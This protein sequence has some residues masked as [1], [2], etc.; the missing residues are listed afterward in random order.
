MLDV[1]LAHEPSQHYFLPLA[2]AFGP[3]AEEPATAYQ[4]QVLAR[5]RKGPRIGLLIDATYDERFAGALVTAMA[6]DARVPTARGGEVRFIGSERLRA[7]HLQTDAPAQR[8]GRE[9]SNSSLTVGDSM[10][11][12]VLRRVQPGIHPELEVSRFL[13]EAGFRNTPSFLGGIELQAQDGASWALAVLQGR[14]QNQGDGWSWTLDHLKRVLDEAQLMAAPQEGSADPHGIYGALITTL[15]VRVA[16]MHRAFATPVDDPAFAPEPVTP[17]DLQR[18]A[19]DARV[20]GRAARAALQ[21]N[22][23]SIAEEHRQ[24]AE[25]LLADWQPVEERIAE[26]APGGAS[27]LK[28]RLHGD[29]HLGQVLLC[30]DDFSII[31]FEGEPARSIEE[32]RAKHCILKDVGGMLRSFDYAAAASVADRLELQPQHRLAVTQAAEDWQQLAC[33]KFLD[34][35]RSAAEGLSSH[36][37]GEDA[38]RLL[39]LFL[40]E[41]VLYEIAY[42]GANRPSWISIPLGGLLRLLGRAA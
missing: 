40:M 24:E 23:Q 35:Y 19:E 15:G 13:T 41:K 4:A 27:F 30:K 3:E 21:A 25:R 17:A 29:L 38:D 2:L 12:K 7:Q 20:Q 6:G 31:D 8:V 22:R 10:V 28:T 32:R 5:A 42:E 16:E 34:G 37:G 18:W 36:P 14:V 9:Q 39:R 11:L 1:A 33:T 26:L